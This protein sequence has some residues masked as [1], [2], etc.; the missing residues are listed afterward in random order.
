MSDSIIALRKRMA[1]NEPVEGDLS[2]CKRRV[3]VLN[4]WPV[5]LSH[6]QESE[7]RQLQTWLQEEAE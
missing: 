7:L 6:E 3:G 4:D 1:N 2:W 5:A